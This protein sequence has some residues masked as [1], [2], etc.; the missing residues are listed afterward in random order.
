MGIALFT[1]LAYLNFRHLLW[2]KGNFT[3]VCWRKRNHKMKKKHFQKV[4]NHCHFTCLRF[5]KNS[6]SRN[7]YDHA[8]WIKIWLP[9][10]HKTTGKWIQKYQKTNVV[11]IETNVKIYE[12]T[13]N[14][15]WEKGCNNNKH[16]YRDC[17]L[18]L[19]IMLVKYVNLTIRIVSAFL[20]MKNGKGDR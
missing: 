6:T 13:H 20:N 10:D 7:S 12:N 9:F 3:N 11:S 2:T 5:E 14:R 17:S 18:I 15:T 4:R 1:R 8:R 19:L 16:K